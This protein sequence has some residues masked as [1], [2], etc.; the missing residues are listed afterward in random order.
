MEP[1]AALNWSTLELKLSSNRA[2]LEPGGPSISLCF[3]Y[4]SPIHHAY[5]PSGDDIDLSSGDDID[6]PSGD[7]IDLPSGDDIDLPSGD[8]ID[9]PSGDDMS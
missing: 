6:L 9:L 8:D 7:D 1:G 5:L 2:Q 3:Q 4:M